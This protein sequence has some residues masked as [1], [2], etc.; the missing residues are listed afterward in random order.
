MEDLPDDHEVHVMDHPPP[1]PGSPDSTPAPPVQ[2]TP[3]PQHIPHFFMQQKLTAMIN[4]YRLLA[5]DASGQPGQLIAFA[6]QKRMKLKEEVNFFADEARTT[7]LFSFKSRQKIDMH[8]RTDILDQAGNQIAW[9]EKDF[10]QSLL[11]STWHIHYGDVTAT[12]QERSMPIAVLRRVMDDIPFRFHFD[13]TDGAT[14]QV[15]MS[16][17]RQRSLRDRYEVTVADPRLPF[18]VAAAITVAL[19][20]FQ[21][22]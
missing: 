10:K 17:D 7:P 16:V 8:A 6:E 21:G 22:R 3:S 5:P 4:R 11:R 20:A 12:G 14:G 2:P 19:D 13:F 15:V 18:H 1:P 9:F